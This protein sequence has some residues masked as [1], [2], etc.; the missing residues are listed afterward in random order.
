MLE[1]GNKN[2]EIFDKILDELE[3]SKNSNVTFF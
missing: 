1:Y 2:T 3:Y